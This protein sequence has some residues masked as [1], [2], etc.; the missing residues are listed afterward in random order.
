MKHRVASTDD[1]EEG[2]RVVTEIE[3]IE[4]AVF[5]V[6]GEYH[7]LANYCVHQGGP[8]C[9]GKRTG[10]MEVGDDGVSWEYDDDPRYVVCPWHEWKFDVTTGVNV[11]DD[12]YVTPTFDVTVEENEVYVHR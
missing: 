8:L 5:Y 1:F 6:D 12:R 3:G 7:A 10:K 2:S 9:E 11:S 4:I